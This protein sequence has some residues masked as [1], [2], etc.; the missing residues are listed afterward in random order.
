MATSACFFITSVRFTIR[1]SKRVAL[2][3]VSDKASIACPMRAAVK[4]LANAT[5]LSHAR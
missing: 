4:Y 5:P 1:K 2:P 3:F